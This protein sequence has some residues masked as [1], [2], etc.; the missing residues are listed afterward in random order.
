MILPHSIHY[1]QLDK[2]GKL[3]SGATKPMHIIIYQSWVIE[4]EQSDVNF[5][6]IDVATEKLTLM[7]TPH[8]STWIEE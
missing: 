4:D 8:P 2:D 1:R 3:P 5:I 7:V 6:C